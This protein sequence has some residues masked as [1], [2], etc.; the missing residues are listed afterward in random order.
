M[1]FLTTAGHIHLGLTM[2]VP[3]FYESRKWDISDNVHQ[4][5]DCPTLAENIYRTAINDH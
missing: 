1:E 5:A 3:G 4:H 2:T